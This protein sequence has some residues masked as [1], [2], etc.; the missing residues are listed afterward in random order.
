M[1][2]ILSRLNQVKRFLLR[3]PIVFIH[4]CLYRLLSLNSSPYP[5][6]LTITSEKLS[7]D[8]LNGKSLIRFGDGEAM[9]MVG[10]DIHFQKY[11]K[12][13]QEDLNK[14]VT[15]YCEESRYILALPIFALTES[16]ESLDKRG[17]LKIWR[18]FKIVF[19]HLFPKNVP[20]ADAMFFYHLQTFE[21]FVVP[22]LN[23]RL[24]LI[25]T[26]QD[27]DRPELRATLTQKNVL[28]E[29]IYTKKSNSF[30]DIDSLIETI[31]QKKKSNPNLI[32]LTS[33]GPGGK[34][35]AYRLTEEHIQCIDIGHGLEIIGQ[36]ADY[37]NRI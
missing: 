14:I 5:S 1:E 7:D 11:E 20:F 19:L 13:L 9:L 33:M 31:H 21:K 30:D 35:L 29:F 25:L 22:V 18:L 8:I 17:R 10:S 2:K 6:L 37:S 28:Y 4:Y 24:V 34:S 16:I 26:N 12:I 23:N 36:K 3:Y 32:I 15:T 27:N